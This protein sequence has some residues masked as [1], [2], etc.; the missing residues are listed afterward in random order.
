M[1][2]SKRQLGLFEDV[3]PRRTGPPAQPVTTS[4]AAAAAIAE[5]APTLRG[6]VYQAIAA[7]GD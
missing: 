6:K 1:R 3:I 2:A 5:M 4:I 7:S